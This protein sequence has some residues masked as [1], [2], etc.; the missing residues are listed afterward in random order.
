MC[1]CVYVIRVLIG[2]LR[3]QL[4]R[5]L[6]VDNKRKMRDA[7]PRY[8]VGVAQNA[9]RENVSVLS[10]Y[11]RGVPSFVVVRVDRIEGEIRDVKFGN[12][13]YRIQQLHYACH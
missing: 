12:V 1:V 4:A 2:P 5:S 6:S 10:V 7:F 13:K 9:L 11:R 8:A 3:Y